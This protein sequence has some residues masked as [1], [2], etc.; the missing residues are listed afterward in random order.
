MQ[1]THIPAHIAIIQDGNRR[2]AKEMGI[3][4][5]KGHRAGADKTEEMLDWAHDLGIRY[6]TIYSFYTENF[7]RAEDEVQ[8]L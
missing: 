7:N 5:A 1:F 4:T 2:F 6:I 8:D 3:D